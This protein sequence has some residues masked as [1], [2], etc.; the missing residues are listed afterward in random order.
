MQFATSTA[1]EA[2]PN[3]GQA[4][5]TQIFVR[6]DIRGTR[7][8]SSAIQVCRTPMCPYRHSAVITSYQY[9]NIYDKTGGRRGTMYP[10]C[11]SLYG[12]VDTT[13]RDV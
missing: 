6:L 12:K 11:W 3:K 4:N 13:I 7:L 2:A 5:A 10:Y 8:R 9:M 1:R